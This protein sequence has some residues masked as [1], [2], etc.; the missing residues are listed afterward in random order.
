M[1]KHPDNLLEKVVSLCKRLGFIFPGSEIYGGLT[2]F[3]DY[4]P[5]GVE[6]KNN[7]KKMWW[8][9]M[10][11]QRDEVVGLDAA[12]IMN[13]QTWEASGHTKSLV[14]PLVECKT[15]HK[16]VRADQEDKLKEHEE[17][18]KEKVEWTEP[19]TFSQAGLD[20]VKS[21]Q[22]LRACDYGVIFSGNKNKVCQI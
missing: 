12:I 6:L 20:S 1:S 10:V 18:H 5:L 13:S 17:E 22:T 11:Y 2:G 8:Q 9:D 4:G 15:C 21:F 7:I 16:R 14:D 19:K 3:W